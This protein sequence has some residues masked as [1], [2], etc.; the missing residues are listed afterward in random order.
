MMGKSKDN[1]KIIIILFLFCIFI[2]L[3]FFT[4]KSEILGSVIGVSRIFDVNKGLVEIDKSKMNVCC[5]F[6]DNGIEKVCAVF[7]E[8]SCD[9]CKECNQGD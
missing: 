8:Y 9:Y 1:K 7:E 2:T 4:I 3:F 5:T 6:D